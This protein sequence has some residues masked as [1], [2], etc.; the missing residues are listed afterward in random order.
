M[1]TCL[2]STPFDPSISLQD[3]K[4]KGRWDTCRLLDSYPSEA[5]LWGGTPEQHHSRTMS[6]HVQHLARSDDE[7]CQKTNY[8]DLNGPS[9]PADLCVTP[10]A[11]A[12]PAC[13]TLGSPIPASAYTTTT[14]TTD[15][16]CSHI[17]RSHD[18]SSRH[19][20]SDES[21]H[22][23]QQRPYIAPKWR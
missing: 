5:G 21:T 1:E 4:C 20:H 19:Q 22:L 10:C 8:D 9:Q 6:S 3:V 12:L 18:A 23:Q 16:R 13:T 15:K 7:T 2:S 11:S 17:R 14:S